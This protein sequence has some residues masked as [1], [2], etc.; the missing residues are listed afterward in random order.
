MTINP[1]VNVALFAYAGV[2]PA[3]CDSLLRDLPCIP[4]LTYS[5]VSKDALISRSRSTAATD[6]LRSDTNPDLMI[7]I[8]HDISW[9][10]GDLLRL[11]QKVAETESVVGGVY[12][13]RIFGQGIAAKPAAKG[14]HFIGSDELIP[15]EYVSAGFLGI[16][17]KVLEKVAEILP[18]TTANFWPFFMP[19]LSAKRSDGRPEYLSED[20]AFCERARNLGFKLFLDPK[21][22]LVHNGRYAYRVI[23]GH[24]LPAAEHP[25]SKQ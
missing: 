18:L 10:P 17:R 25:T 9:Q 24:S 2:E 11:V 4:N 5:R 22:C 16:H 1:K 15:A 3:T 20:W 23:D 19:M 14:G 8:D 12:S 6:F 21:P 13:K 7:M